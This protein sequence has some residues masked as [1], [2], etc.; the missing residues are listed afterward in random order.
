MTEVVIRFAGRYVFAQSGGDLHVLAI[1][2]M[3]DGG[4]KSQPHAVFF[5]APQ[6]GGRRP[7]AA[8]IAAAALTEMTPT[9]RLLSS[10]HSSRADH[11]VWNFWHHDVEI[12]VRDQLEQTPAGFSWGQGDG[13][14]L[15]DLRT[16]SGGQPFDRRL[17]SSAN[18]M[19]DMVVSVV[20]LPAGIGVA[21]QVVANKLPY[22]FVKFGD[23]GTPIGSTVQL[24]DI[25]EITLAV[26]SSL[27]L[28]VTSRQTGERKFITVAA[29]S[30]QP[31]I[32]NFTNLCTVSHEGPD[33]EFAA[34]YNV[35][36]PVPPL[37]D[38][39]IPKVALSP[40]LEIPFG[41][42]YPGGLVTY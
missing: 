5:T 33:Q 23:P 27:D 3:A 9:Y 40:L 10:S 4:I 28:F 15:A 13:S 42:C 11:G 38:R 24:A 8:R 31:S 18:P 22:R 1:N 2:P 20:H 14:V 35:L 21:R 36:D 32:V 7:H 12:G 19:S 37:T 34:L 16:L 29:D 41:D 30:V 26:D 6:R 39:K 17:I 25:V